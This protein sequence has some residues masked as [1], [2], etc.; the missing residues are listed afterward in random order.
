[1]APTE[2]DRLTAGYLAG[3]SV[4]ELAHQFQVHRN[5]VSQILERKGIARRYRLMGGDKLEAAVR[6]YESGNSLATIGSDL[7]SA[8]TLFA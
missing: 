7:V 4:Y 3:S 6:A 1:L 2:I 8:L 5:T